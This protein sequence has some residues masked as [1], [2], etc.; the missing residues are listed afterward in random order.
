MVRDLCCGGIYVDDEKFVD[1]IILNNDR[2][3]DLIIVY[4]VYNKNLYI[5]LGWV[6]LLVGQF[7]AMSICISR[8]V[9]M[10]NAIIN[11]IEMETLSRSFPYLG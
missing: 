4:A 8:K 11:A 7:V 2:V 3:A 1:F 9:E 6:L 10:R 5:A